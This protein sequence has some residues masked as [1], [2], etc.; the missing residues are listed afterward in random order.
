MTKKQFALETH[1]HFQA[2][3]F[4]TYL[5][6]DGTRNNNL[7]VRQPGLYSITVTNNCGTAQDEVLVTDGICKVW[8][9]SA[10]TPNG[11][12]GK[13]DVFKVLGNLNFDKFQLSVYNRWGQRIFSTTDPSKGWD[14]FLNG[15]KQSTGVFAWHCTFKESNGSATTT[16]K[17]TVAVIR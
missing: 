11:D 2:G 6:Q 1:S 5:W 10:F 4:D 9:P 16:I 15:Q 17:G 7:I 12:N 8:F 14:G 13:N 3:Q